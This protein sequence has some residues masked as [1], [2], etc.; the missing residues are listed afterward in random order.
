[1]GCHQANPGSAYNGK[2]KFRYGFQAGEYPERIASEKKYLFG[3]LKTK[4]SFF[5]AKTKELI[6][7]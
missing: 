6:G 4:A 2:P 1:M 5:G 7:R 3:K